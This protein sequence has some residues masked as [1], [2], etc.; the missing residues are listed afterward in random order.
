MNTASS[1]LPPGPKGLPF[2]GSAIAFQRNPL[3]FVRRLQSEYGNVATV[4]IGKLP[5]V[6]CFRPE[7]V[8]YLLTE[9][10]KNFKKANRNRNNLK[11]V[12][13]DGLLTID[14]EYHRQ[15]RRLVQ[16]AFH[17]RRI[18]SYASVMTEYTQE[19][20]ATWQ[21]SSEIDMSQAM[22]QLTLRIIGQTLFHVDLIDRS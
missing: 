15:Q 19:M 9:H 16:P 22:Q 17:K 3:R 20:L 21:P 12:L 1:Q 2:F 5:F 14:G 8:R 10:Q 4:S 11:R 18:E 6:F 13:G 7:H